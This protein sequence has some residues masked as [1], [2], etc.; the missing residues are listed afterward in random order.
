MKKVLTMTF[1]LFA[2]V[3]AFAQFPEYKFTTE[4]ENPITS[5]KNQ[6]RS[7]TCWAFSTLGF[8]E[9]E[10]IRINGI[11]DAANYPDLSEMFVVSKSYQDRAEKYVRLDGLLNFSPGSEA[12]DVLHVIADYGMV[13]QS[14]MPGLAE[15][16]VHAELDAVTKA[17]V[18]AIAK[19]PGRSLSPYWKDG[20]RGIC[21]AYLGACPESFEIN[22]KTLTPAQYRDELKFNPSDYVTISSFTH[23]PFYTSFVFEVCDN[24]RYDKTWN[25]PLDEFIEVLDYALSHGFTA[26]WGTDVSDAGFTRDGLA[27]LVDREKK[28]TAGSDQEHWVGKAEEK[29]EEFDTVVE[30]EA[31]QESHQA[32]FDTKAVTDDHGMQIY[33]VAHDQFGKKYYMVKNS[34][35][36][37]GKYNGIWYATE[38]FVR[39]QSIDI[40][41]HKD[42]LP[43]H[44]AKK[45]GIK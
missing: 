14:A 26:A 40:M 19:N 32:D 20:F 5:V 37:T 16:P 23:H 8:V 6:Y 17:Y 36:E 41:V 11:K 9:S 28:N 4:F 10:I 7:S 2:G 3:A 39:N 42:A 45:L 18:Q 31:T 25:L 44:I 38:A 22:G 43:K 30:R 29:P 13:P 1:A 12:D 34:W 15:K 27:I 21:D 33:G 24:W 35:G